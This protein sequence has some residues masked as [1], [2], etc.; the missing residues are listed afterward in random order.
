MAYYAVS[1]S[2]KFTVDYYDELDFF[3]KKYLL[4]RDNLRKK[5]I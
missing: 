2:Y 5:T 4:L 1:K 3:R